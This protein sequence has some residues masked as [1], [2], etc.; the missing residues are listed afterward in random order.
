MY[1][2]SDISRLFYTE[3]QRGLLFV[4]IFTLWINKKLSYMNILIDI[5]LQNN[6]QQL[7]YWQDPL[8]F[9]L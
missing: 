7:N 5:L 6:K 3:T 1:I 4:K 2:Q 9:A 8:E